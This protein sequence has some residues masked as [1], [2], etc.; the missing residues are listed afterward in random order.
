MHTRSPSLLLLVAGLLLTACAS[1]DPP[2]AAVDE[3][4][5]SAALTAWKASRADAIDGPH[6]WITLVGLWWLHEGNNTVG[7][8][9]SSDIVL[10]RDRAPGQ[11]GVVRVAGQTVT[12]ETAPHVAVTA[13]DHPVS[14]VPLSADT[15]STPTVLRLGSLTLR[16]LERSGQWALRA[17]DTAHPLR[18]T[19][20]GLRYFPVDTTWRL[21]GWFRRHR[22]VDSLRIVTIVNTVERQ[23]SPGAVE[24]VV[25][26]R[27]YRLDAV[28]GQRDTALFVMFRDATS[29]DSTYPAGR[30]LEVSLPDSLGRVL[31]DFNR[32]TN[33]P[34]AFTAF[35][36]CPIPP[37]QNILPFRIP[38]GELRPDHGT[39]AQLASSNQPTE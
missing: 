4:A 3:A 38:A 32:A 39:H 24:F 28:R 36:T 6:G 35:A 37:R 2:P 15:A 33:P 13:D 29:A 23:A 18:T 10:P 9:S 17:K 20:A 25:G 26:G 31:V 8:D 16:L 11:V 7:S 27:R 5:Y 14:S 22:P 34:C 12:F 30:Y 1:H 19:F 21:H